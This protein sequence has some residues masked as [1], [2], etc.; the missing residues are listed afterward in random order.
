MVDIEATE[1]H[2]MEGWLCRS[3]SDRGRRDRFWSG[4]RAR[5]RVDIPAQSEEE[6]PELSFCC[7]EK[8]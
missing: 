4:R 1:A 2:C 7:T 5:M 8:R 6:A 3:I